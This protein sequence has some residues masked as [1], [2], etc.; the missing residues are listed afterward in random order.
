[1]FRNFTPYIDITQVL[2][3]LFWFAFF[4]LILYLRREDKRE[5]YPLTSNE[6]GRTVQGFPAYPGPKEFIPTHP[7]S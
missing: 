1:M 2:L 3:Y 7:E 4:G 5:G 6:S